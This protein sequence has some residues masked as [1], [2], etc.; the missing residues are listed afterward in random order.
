LQNP[1]K[2]GADVVIHSTTKYIN[3][4]SDSLG[5]AIVLNNEELF[6]KIKFH[7]N[8][9]GAVMSP[10]DSYLTAR[11]LKTLELRMNTHSHNA[12]RIAK[13]LEEHKMVEK[14]YYPGLESHE[15][16]KI[17]REQM[18]NFGGMLSFRYSGNLR[19]FLNKLNYFTLAESLGGIESLI[20]V[21]YYMTHASLL[22]EER[23]KLGI[24]RRL[25]RVSVGIE[26]VED[27][28]EDLQNSL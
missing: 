21:P 11:G 15:G 17:A 25:I 2:L 27:L 28:L 9:I 22:E 7:Q 13:F 26:N 10:F 24:D 6:E 20:E 1:L 14:V 5:G 8:A 23:N 16:Y 18:K 12:I 3:G 19:S 4:H